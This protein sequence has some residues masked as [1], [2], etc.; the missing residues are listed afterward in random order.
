MPS[1]VTVTGNTGGWTGF[2]TGL[3]FLASE[4]Q[5]QLRFVFNSDGSGTSDGI[6]YALELMDLFVDQE[7]KPKLFPLFDDIPV[8]DKMNK[9][10]T[11]F[12][13][14]AYNPVQVVNYILNR[15]FNLNN[16]WTKMCAVYASAFI[17]EFRVSRG[18]IGQMFNP[19]RLLQE[20]AA[21]GHLQ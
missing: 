11:Y 21:W 20:T 6:A 12:P 13:R 1:A 3:S 4:P 15:D 14:E 8:K 5:V 18:L 16:R 7:M 17:P 2:G 10:Q 9:L 19:D